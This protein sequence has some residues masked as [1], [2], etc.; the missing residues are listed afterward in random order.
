MPSIIQNRANG[1]NVWLAVKEI[2]LGWLIVATTNQGIC[3][4]DFGESSQASL[5]QLSKEYGKNFK[6]FLLVILLVINRSPKKL[7]IQKRPER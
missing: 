3:A 6:I 2:W 1:N 5:R 4:I 7:A